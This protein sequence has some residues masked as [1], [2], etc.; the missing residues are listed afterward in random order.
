MKS[1][2]D[3]FREKYP[4]TILMMVTILVEWGILEWYWYA[5]EGIVSLRIG[6]LIGVAC[7]PI[8]YLIY[9]YSKEQGIYFGLAGIGLS[10]LAKIVII[11][12]SCMLFWGVW[13]FDL[14]YLIPP[15]FLSLLTINFFAIYF[16]FS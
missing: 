10:F 7:Y 9:W 3:S 11:F 16:A 5:S 14:Q 8:I 13:S 2:I 15:L 1:M 4:I 12:A 6:F